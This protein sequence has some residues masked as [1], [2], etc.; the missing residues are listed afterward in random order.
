MFSDGH[1]PHTLNQFFSSLEY[2]TYQLFVLHSFTQY[3]SSEQEHILKLYDQWGNLEFYP[4]EF[5]T[6]LFFTWTSDNGI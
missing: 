3:T 2:Y 6:K 1:Y 5:V 4:L